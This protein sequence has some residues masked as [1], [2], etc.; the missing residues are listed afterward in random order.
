MARCGRGFNLTHLPFM[1][2]VLAW[3]PAK[4]A[5]I[6]TLEKVQRRAFRLVTD[7]GKVDY[8]TKLKFADRP[9]LKVD[10][11]VGTSSRSL[12]L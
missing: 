8:E 10:E 11:N 7:K 9:R 5:D 3:N 1:L 6:N 4:V 2:E 12:K